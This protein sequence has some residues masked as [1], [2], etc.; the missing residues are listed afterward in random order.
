MSNFVKNVLQQYCRD[1]LRYIT[2]FYFLTIKE[3]YLKDVLIVR[4]RLKISV[5]KSANQS[6][7]C[8]KMHFKTNGKKQFGL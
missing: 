5:I 1:L 2:S 8:N 6:K 7:S 3:K 4:Y